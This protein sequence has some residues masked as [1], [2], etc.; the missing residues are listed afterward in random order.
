MFFLIFLRSK[1]LVSLFKSNG[2]AH[3]KNKWYRIFR[4]ITKATILPSLYMLCSLRRLIYFPIVFEIDFRMYQ[5]M[6]LPPR[7]CGCETPGSATQ[8][9]KGGRMIVL[10]NRKLPLS[11]D[12]FTQKKTPFFQNA[13]F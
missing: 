2:E 7:S 9:Q 3:C 10:Q 12:F 1:R 5:V 8:T 4:Q 6:V 11:T 13:D